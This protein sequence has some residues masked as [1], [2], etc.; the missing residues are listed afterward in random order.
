MLILQ[1]SATYYGERGNL[2][3]KKKVLYAKYALEIA[4]MQLTAW[5]RLLEKTWTETNGTVSELHDFCKSNGLVAPDVGGRILG[6]AS[7]ETPVQISHT[8][9]QSTKKA[10]LRGEDGEAERPSYFCIVTGV[11]QLHRRS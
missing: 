4:V 9:S 5:L 3:E 2:E 8:D 1:A 11:E 7:I 10:M 6:R